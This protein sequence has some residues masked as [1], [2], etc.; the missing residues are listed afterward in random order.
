MRSEPGFWP[1]RNDDQRAKA[2]YRGIPTRILRDCSRQ[3]SPIGKLM[4]PLRR[5][6]S[7]EL[8]GGL[9]LVGLA[10]RRQRGFA[11]TGPH[12]PAGL[13]NLVRRPGGQVAYLR[14]LVADKPRSRNYGVMASRRSGTRFVGSVGSRCR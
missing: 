9:I 14:R 11:V 4:P 1:G 6:G 5:F 7:G 12:Q 10:D 8:D 2:V 3:M 13:P